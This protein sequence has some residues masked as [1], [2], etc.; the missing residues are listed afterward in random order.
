[1]SS[2]AEAVSA[3][4]TVP[5]EAGRWDAATCIMT[6]TTAAPAVAARQQESATG[7]MSRKVTLDNPP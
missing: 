6:I 3:G 4:T 2:F 5:L 1:M 7:L